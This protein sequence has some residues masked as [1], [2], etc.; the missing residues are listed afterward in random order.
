[1]ARIRDGF[2]KEDKILFQRLICHAKISL[3]E[4]GLFTCDIGFH[5]FTLARCLQFGHLNKKIGVLDRKGREQAMELAR[6]NTRVSGFDFFQASDRHNQDSRQRLASQ[7][8]TL[9]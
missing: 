3:K 2:G 7:I 8:G 5:L 9:P 1:M 6:K 4:P